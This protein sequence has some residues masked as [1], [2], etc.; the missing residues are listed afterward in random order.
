MIKLATIAGSDASG[1]AG[2]EADLKTFQEYGGYGMAAITVIATMNP[3]AEWEHAVFPIDEQCLRSQLETIFNGVGVDA[4]KTGMLGT[5]YAVHLT[6]EY[7]NKYKIKNFVLDP[8]MVCKGADL[9]LNPELNELI[10]QKLLPIAKIIM[11]NL[12][13]AGQIAKV[14]TPKTIEEMQE[15]A[16]I[17]HDM[18]CP[19]VFIKGGAHLQGQSSAVDVFYDGTEFHKVEA[20]LIQTTWTHGAGCTTAAAVTAGLG[21]GL[22]PYDAVLRA[23]KF[24]TLS[25]R[26]GFEMNRWGGAGNPSA[27]RK[28][29]N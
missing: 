20:E 16:K 17:I 25:L 28:P 14:P 2:L 1:G 12:F 21:A 3:N 15:A 9:A 4:V 22:A 19:F 6:A 11:P 7:L 23:K 10:V 13:E 27:W 5:P 18:G 26:N 24:I 29:F 8:V